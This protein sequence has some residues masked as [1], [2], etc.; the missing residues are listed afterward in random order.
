MAL[1]EPEPGLVIHFEYLWRHEAAQG[2]VEGVK[3]RPCAVILA[4][5]QNGAPGEAT[6][7]VMV[8][9]ITHRP[10]APPDVAIEIPAAVKNHLGLDRDRSWIVATDLNLFTWPGPDL[11]PVPGREPSVFA[12]GFLPPKLFRTVVRTIQASAKG[13]ATRRED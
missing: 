8:A 10:P 2:R 12:Y 1:P 4:I 7:D 5:R 13:G 6:T 9:P 3:A 11:R